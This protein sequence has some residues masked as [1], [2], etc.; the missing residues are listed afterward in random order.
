MACLAKGPSE[1][2][3]LDAREAA[4][5]LSGQ[6]LNTDLYVKIDIV[7]SRTVPWGGT[8]AFCNENLQFEAAYSDTNGAEPSNRWAATY[9]VFKVS[10]GSVTLHNNDPNRPIPVGRKWNAQYRFMENIYASNLKT[11][12][13]WQAEKMV[14]RARKAGLEEVSIMNVHYNPVFAKLGH[15]ALVTTEALLLICRAHQCLTMTGDFNAACY[16]LY[17]PKRA[18]QQGGARPDPNNCT[19]AVAMEMFE[20][21]YNTNTPWQLQ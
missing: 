20:N 16:R 2:Q 11:L 8:A 9:A 14:C 19:I 7:E 5:A 3:L 6:D 21:A 10:F 17:N 12:V 18:D 13:P 4:K 15:R 1:A